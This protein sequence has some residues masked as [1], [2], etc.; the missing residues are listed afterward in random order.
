M[1]K[2]LLGIAGILAM[3]SSANAV[4][5]SQ[6]KAACQSSD[7]TLWVERNQVCIPRNPCKDARYDKYCNRVFRDVQTH[8]NLYKGLIELYADTH[9]LSCVPVE[10]DSKAFGQDYVVCKGIDVMVFEFNDIHDT[11]SFWK[12]P[13]N[14][15]KDLATGLCS[16]VDG[17]FD[18]DVC[19]GINR[20]TCAKISQI[21]KKYDR[22]FLRGDD[23]KRYI[24]GASWGWADYKTDSCIIRTNEEYHPVHYLYEYAPDYETGHFNDGKYDWE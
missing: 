5:T 4:D 8:G 10:Q 22:E 14:F 2:T 13:L 23:S 17:T 24:S 6:I 16:A 9:N 20:E 21:I 18:E 1:K 11:G 15:Y 19:G 12:L 3:I 7:K